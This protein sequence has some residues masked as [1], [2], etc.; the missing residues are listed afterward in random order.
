[1]EERM[2]DRE[3]RLAL[4]IAILKTGRR[5]YEVAKAAGIHENLLSAALS[6][7]RALSPETLSRLEQVLGLTAATSGGP[8]AA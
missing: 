7:R 8:D 4:K 3:T 5:Q 1:M 2:L 6:G